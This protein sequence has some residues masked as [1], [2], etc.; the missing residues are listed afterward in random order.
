MSSNKETVVLSTRVPLTT[1]AECAKFLDSM[2]REVSSR[3]GLVR[4]SM[5]VLSK[6]SQA[7]GIVD[8]VNSPS[9]AVT[10]LQSYGIDFSDNEEAMG[11]VAEAISQEAL[12]SGASPETARSKEVEQVLSVDEEES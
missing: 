7:E 10:I 1:L 3:S 12:E 2:G 5:E 8:S 11:Q 6:A 4:K 9:R